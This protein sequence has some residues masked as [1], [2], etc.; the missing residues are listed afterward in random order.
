MIIGA[1]VR[2]GHATTGPVVARGFGNISTYA[3]LTPHASTECHTQRC[4]H[5]HQRQG[6]NPCWRNRS[7]SQSIYQRLQ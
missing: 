2:L 3:F 4:H 5:T 6:C 1:E 7:R